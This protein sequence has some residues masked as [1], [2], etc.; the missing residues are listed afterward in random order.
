[1]APLGFEDAGDG[2]FRLSGVLGFTTVTHALAQS[3]QLFAEHKRV[4]IDLAGV[5]ATDSAGLA[6]LVEWTAW[7]KH[8]KRKLSFKHLP[9]QALELARISEVE[10]LLPVA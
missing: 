8:E 6:L 3:R 7:A 9:K 5:E 4:E 2:R 1:M 10:K